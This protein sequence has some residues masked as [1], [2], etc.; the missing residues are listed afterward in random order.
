M[1]FQNR[2]LKFNTAVAVLASFPWMACGGNV[3]AE[4][5]SAERNPARVLARLADDPRLAL[6]PQEKEYLRQAARR[7][8]AEPR[9]TAVHLPAAPAEHD[10]AAE[11]QQIAAELAPLADAAAPAAKRLDG[12]ALKGL[13]E[14]L[15]GVHEQTLKEFAAVADRLRDA[16]L[17]QIILDRQEA[18]RADYLKNVQQVFQD[19]DAARKSQ[20]P[21]AARSALAAAAKRLRR[22]TNERPPQKLDPSRLPFRTAR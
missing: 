20:D 5:R 15:E 17:P 11:M 6:S 14:R 18:A 4:A 16:R 9:R 21:G 3:W 1:L 8:E 22:S 7:I 10:P 19:L 2:R 13:V 12:Q